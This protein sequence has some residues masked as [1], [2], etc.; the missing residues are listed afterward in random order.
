ML[1]LDI[2]VGSIPTDDAIGWGFDSCSDDD[3]GVR[4]WAVACP[5]DVGGPVRHWVRLCSFLTVT[6]RSELRVAGTMWQR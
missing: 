6:E 5:F 3:D 1:S 2:T 4:S